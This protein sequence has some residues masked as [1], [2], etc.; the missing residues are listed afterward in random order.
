MCGISGLVVASGL[1]F[2]PLSAVAR[3]ADSLRH[4]GPDD[5]GIWA[6]Q[7]SRVVFGFR[8]LAIIDLS[9]AGHQPM[10]SQSG[11]WVIVFNG[12]V[13]NFRELRKMLSEEGV[14]FRGHSDTEVIVEAI[15]KWGIQKTVA[16]LVGMFAIAIW[17]QEG[18]CL[19][20]VRDRIGIKPLYW[21]QL[22]GCLV[23]A[24]ELKALRALPYWTPQIDPSSMAQFVRYGYVAGPSTIYKNVQRMEPGTLLNYRPGRTPEVMRYWDLSS[25]AES[26]RADPSDIDESELVDHLERLLK[27]AVARRMVADVP[28]GAFLSGGVDSSTVVSLMQAQSSRPIRTF[29][30]G[31]ETKKYDE[32]PQAKLI[33][34]H[35]G[36]DHTELYVDAGD[37]LATIPKLSEIYDEPFADPS[38]I[39]TILVCAMARRHVTVALSGD[40]GDELFAG[41]PRYAN[42]ARI[43]EGVRRLPKFSQ[44]GSAGLLRAASNALAAAGADNLARKT[45]KVADAA[46]FELPEHVHQRM[47]SQW[48]DPASVVPGRPEDQLMKAHRASKV[49]D[50]VGRMQLADMLTYLPEDILTKLDRASMAV[51][52]EARVPLLDHRLV[53]FIWSLPATMIQRPGNPKW[54]LRTV[55]SRYVPPDLIDRRKMGFSVPMDSWLRGPL[56]EWAEDLLT[57]DHLIS[58]GFSDPAPIRRRWREHLSG[59]Y[60][61]FDALWNILMFQAWHQRWF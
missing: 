7:D 24:S 31:F 10:I 49:P 29:T 15:A 53:E 1:P 56:R 17:D 48:N 30:I 3:M 33:A 26:G 46:G 28:L 6:D 32:A 23:F 2:D 25:I 16:S 61:H 57:E 45:A 34:Q 58:A 42:A 11:R 18:R 20:L 55:L 9:P 43:V 35:L 21:A 12:E 52:L 54:L 39:P 8:R 13:F 47:V 22:S 19:T 60:N 27:D 14:G 41:Y 44:V 50:F 5:D 38:Q 40:G 36:T 59:K 4:R 37:A 51:G